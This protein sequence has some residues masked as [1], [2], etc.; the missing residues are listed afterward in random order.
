MV[1]LIGLARF[2][3]QA[4]VCLQ[5]NSVVAQLLIGTT[6]HQTNPFVC[7]LPYSA[8]KYNSLTLPHPLLNRVLEGSVQT[9]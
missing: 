7:V 9:R 4:I 5:E 3:H 6:L 2:L 8:T 1:G